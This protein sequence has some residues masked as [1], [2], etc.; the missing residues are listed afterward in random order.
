[1]S[2]SYLAVVFKS[3]QGR[4]KISL[5]L[6]AFERILRNQLQ[7]MLR[8]LVIGV[9]YVDTRYTPTPGEIFNQVGDMAN[10]QCKVMGWSC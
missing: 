10:A 2:P 1:M 4:R 9:R 7:D 3:Q 8:A 5:P 6:K